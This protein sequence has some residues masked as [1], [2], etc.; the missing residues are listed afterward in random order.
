MIEQFLKKYWTYYIEIEHQVMETKRYIEFDTNN[1]KAFSNEYLML[2][3]AIGSEIDVVGKEIANYS[4][5]SFN[6][7]SN[8]H[9]GIYNWFY[10]VQK[11]FPNIRNEHALF[12]S[13]KDMYPFA[14]C[15]IVPTK[16]PV[17]YCKDESPKLKL[18]V[19]SL[20]NW[21]KYYNKVKHQR[22][23]LV[24]GTSFYQQANQ[25]NVVNS[26]AAL[27]LLETLFIELLQTREAKT[28]DKK[29]SQLFIKL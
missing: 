10:E 17:E 19:K 16:S 13:S 4:N 3:Q 28:I 15:F 12:F 8:N 26:L 1:R 25:A 22:V 11:L 18:G 20:P 9:K 29:E 21:W 5:A 14:G 27:F 7:Y 24:V 2:Y 6:G 23:G